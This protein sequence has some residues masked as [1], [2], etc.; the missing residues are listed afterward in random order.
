MCILRRAVDIV[1]HLSLPLVGQSRGFFHRLIAGSLRSDTVCNAATIRSEENDG[2]G[3]SFAEEVLVDRTQKPRMQLT[4]CST[5]RD[6][7]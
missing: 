4:S 7:L 6:Q 2:F 1:D 3:N 5:P